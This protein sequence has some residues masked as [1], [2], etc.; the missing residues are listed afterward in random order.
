LT[1]L[2]PA[3]LV[4]VRL[5][6][7]RLHRKCLSPILGKPAITWLVERLKLAR[8]ASSIVLC[9]T[10]LPEDK[11]FDYLC[12]ELGVLV[13]HGDVENVLKRFF[14][15]A[16]HFHHEFIIIA[17][18][19]DLFCD[20]IQ[21]DRV[22]EMAQAKDLD[23]IQS[24]ELPFGTNPTGLRTKAIGR[25]LSIIDE[26]DTG[27][28]GRFFNIPGLFKVEAIPAYDSALT[29]HAF[30]LTLDYPEDLTLFREIFNTLYRPESIFSL[31]EIVDLL[32]S[33]PDIAQINMMKNEDY[34]KNYNEKYGGVKYKNDF[35]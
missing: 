20:P 27:G 16:S 17:D 21:I 32:I 22:I 35:R 28:F 13:F 34:W 24:T 19:D 31:R 15:A 25:V 5:G 23:Y 3:V 10:D 8:K 18:G 2:S 11:I 7:T 26:E 6:S 33:R 30:R 14:D 9:T 29:G 4:P 12:E 1:L